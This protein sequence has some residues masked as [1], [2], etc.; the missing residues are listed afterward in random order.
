MYE[1]S[2]NL[3]VSWLFEKISNRMLKKSAGTL[4]PPPGK[5]G[6][7]NFNLTFKDFLHT[8]FMDFS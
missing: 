3:N 2:R 4:D 8:A 7:N 6:L 5:I 1:K